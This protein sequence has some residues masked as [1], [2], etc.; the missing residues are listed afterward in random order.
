MVTLDGIQEQMDLLKGL[1]MMGY[2]AYYGLPPWEL[3]LLILEDKI[4]Y[5]Q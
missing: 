2:P 4:D 3:T 1:V 5:P